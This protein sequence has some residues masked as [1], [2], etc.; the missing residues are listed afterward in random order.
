[1]LYKLAGSGTGAEIKHKVGA[2]SGSNKSNKNQQRWVEHA[3]AVKS[4][5]LNLAA[6]LNLDG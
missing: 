5:R 2:R 6:L 4:T 1:M 3:R